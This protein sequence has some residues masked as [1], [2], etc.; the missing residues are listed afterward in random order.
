MKINISCLAFDWRIMFALCG[1]IAF[2]ACSNLPLKKPEPP[3]VSVADVRPLNL[4]L[5]EQR[6]AFTLKMENPNAY[7]LPLQGLDFV[8]SFANQ[9]IATGASDQHVTIPANGEAMVEVEVTAG[10]DKI[11]SQIESIL[12]AKA[13]SLDYG[14]TGKVKLANWP[15]KIPFKVNGQI[16]AP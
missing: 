9:E 5:T 11:I 14:V 4:S 8:A 2:S 13:I 12:N 16:D 3:I 15:S 1:L 6:L 10:I 7:D